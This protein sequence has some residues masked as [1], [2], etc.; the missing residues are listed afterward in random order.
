MSGRGVAEEGGAEVGTV[1]G[2]RGSW[3]QITSESLQGEAEPSVCRI[4]S[5]HPLSFCVSFHVSPI[6]IIRPRSVSVS[7]SLSL[8]LCF[9]EGLKLQEPRN[10]GL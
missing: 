10:L 4:L 8:F 9:S 7:K 3:R 2:E 5:P 1:E 6:S